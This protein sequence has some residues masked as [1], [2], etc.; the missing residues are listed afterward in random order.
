MNRGRSSIVESASAESILRVFEEMGLR[1]TR[2]RR[3]IAER[4][5]ALAANGDDFTTDDLWH[6]LRQD[7]PQLGRATVFRAVEVLVQRGLLDR[8]GFADGSH[9]YRL[10]GGHAHHHHITCTE[11]RRVVE[12]G[13]CLPPDVLA[14]VERATGFTL[15][16]HEVELFGC[17]ADCRARMERS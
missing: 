9:C 12:V 4:L 17:C 14:A 8:V 15:E 3:L 16:G 7:D 6:E 1:N 10:C 2:P 5:A 13:A 11:C